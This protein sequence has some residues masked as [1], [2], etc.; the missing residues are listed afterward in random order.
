M[1]QIPTKKTLLTLALAATGFIA[2]PAFAQDSTV[3]TATDQVATSGNYQPGQA[4]GSGNWFA[5]G[6]VGRTNGHNNS[7]F[8]DDGTDFNFFKGNR[9]RRTSY[10]LGGGYRWKVGEDLGLGLDAG[11]VDLGNFRLRNAF[12][13]NS[14]NQKSTQNALRGWTVGVNGHINVLPHWYVSARGGYFNANDNNNHFNNSPGEDLGLTDGRRAKRG[15]W[16]AGLGTGWDINQHFGLGVHYDYYHANAGTIKNE[17][18]G[19][20]TAGLKRSTSVVS[21]RGEYRF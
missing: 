16:Y 5:D 14:V 3:T 10:A 13:S 9:G 19:A 12:N 15:S 7:S 18:T 1:N 6:S 21:L 17:T 20:E 11:Y 2:A 8:A 4:I